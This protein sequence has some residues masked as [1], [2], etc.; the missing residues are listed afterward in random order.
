MSDSARQPFELDGEFIGFVG[1]TEKP[2]YIHLGCEERVMQV[3][4]AKN[5]RSLL[6]TTLEPGTR[7]RVSGRAK[8]ERR[9][10][11]LSLKAERVALLS[12]SD[13]TSVDAELSTTP[14]SDRIKILVCQKSKCR[15]RGGQRIYEA[16]EA[17]VRDRGLQAQVTLKSSG[18]LKRC[19]SAPNLLAGKQRYKSVRLKDVSAILGEYC[20]I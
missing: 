1:H 2:K 9:N 6:A 20:V 5:L 10:G 7:L 8:L 14:G 16:I 12:E 13:G 19:S 17:A 3:K 18:C 4:L 11:Q 15:K